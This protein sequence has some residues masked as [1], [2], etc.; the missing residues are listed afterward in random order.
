M[1]N[2]KAKNR[3]F[4]IFQPNSRPK[5]MRCCVE[6]QWTRFPWWNHWPVGQLPNDGRRTGVPDRPA[7]SSLAQSIE[8]SPVIVHDQENKTF[9]A[10]HLCGMSEK[11]VPGL[12]PL[13][14][15][16]NYPARLDLGGSGFRSE[17]YDRSQRAY[18]LTCENKDNPSTLKFEFAADENSPVVNPAFVIKG[19]GDAGAELKINGK[20]VKRGENYRFGHNHSL[21]GSDLIVWIKKEATE[22]VAI[23]LSPR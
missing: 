16:W 21:E 14:R 10:V 1:V 4:L 7:H 9:T 17:G 23:S 3:P 20:K 6:E 19:W 5:L 13:A 18:V 8:D 22:P 11:A 2:L 15:S 12:V